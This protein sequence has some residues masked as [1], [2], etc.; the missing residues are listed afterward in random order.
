M[1]RQPGVSGLFYPSD[2]DVLKLVLKG[3]KVSDGEK[4][5]VFGIVAPHAGYVYSGQCA[6]DVYSTVK[7]PETVIIL[8]VDHRGETCG[9]TI[10]GHDTWETPLGGVQVNTELRDE[11]LKRNPVFKTS[12]KYGL[13]EHSIEVHLPFLQYLGEN[14]RI[15]PV[16]VSTHDADIL[17]QCGETLGKIAV[18]KGA[19]IVASS[20]MSHFITSEKAEEVDGYAI[21]SMEECDPFG[22][23]KTVYEHRISMCGVSSVTML[24]YAAQ[25]VYRA[26]RGEVVKYTNSGEATGDYS[27]VVAYL[28]VLIP[29]VATE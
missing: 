14:N 7:I 10:D 18:E 13:K 24:L 3:F 12:E 21:R 23:M 15:L 19:L 6:M 16:L 2:P 9:V 5:E 4:R 27:S 1:I 29:K 25:S 20:D 8:G 17:K 28:S 11:I 26:P 22:L